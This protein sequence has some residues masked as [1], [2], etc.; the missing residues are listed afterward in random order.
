MLSVTDAQKMIL[1]EVK[2]ISVEKALVTSALNRVLAEDVVAGISHPPW[3]NSAM[4]GYAIRA[5]DVAGASRSTPVSLKVVQEIQAGRVSEYQL[6]PGEAV[7]IMTGAP[8]PPGADAVVEVEETRLEETTVKIFREVWSGKNIRKRGENVQAGEKVLAQGGLLG[9]PEIGLLALLGKTSIP[10][11]Q[12]PVVAILATGDELTDLD[13][14]LREG[15]IYNSNSY[16]LWGQVQEAGGTPRLLGIVRD[17]KEEFRERLKTGLDSDVVLIS[18]AVSVGK[19]DFARE[20]MVELGVKIRFWTVAIRP[21]HPLVFGTHNSTLVF[22]LPGNPVSTM[23]AFEEF[24]RPVLLKMQ[25]RRDIYPPVVEAILMEPF[26]NHLGRIHFV[27]AIVQYQSASG[28]GEYQVRPAGPQGS[29]ILMSMVKA[30]SLIVLPADCEKVEAGEKVRV[31]L[32][33]SRWGWREDPGYL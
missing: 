2:L 1:N 21:G 27:R 15:Q 29:G 31:Q 8:I 28:G 16:A 19:Y 11:Y 22:G 4:D 10:V 24:V 20:V 7:G 30:N 13:E 12:Q 26:R 23:V 33:G 3:D 18:G 14:P 17:N 25:G 5:Q 9:A 32:L 6:K